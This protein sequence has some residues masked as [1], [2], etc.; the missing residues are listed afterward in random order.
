MRGPPDA[1]PTGGPAFRTLGHAA[2]LLGDEADAIRVVVDPWRGHGDGTAAHA[3]LVT[4]A[5]P[6]HCSEEDLL[7]ATL[8]G[9]PIVAPRGVA[10][11]LER[12]FPG[13][14]VSLDEGGVWT[15]AELPGLAVRA[16]PAE[17]P[18]RAA[19]FHPRGEGLVYL[20]TLGPARFLVLGDST[21]LPE[22]EKLAPDVAFLAVGDFTVMTPEEAAE[23]AARL[24]PRLAVPVHWGDTSGRF[25]A[26]R[27]F[28]ALAAARGIPSIPLRATRQLSPSDEAGRPPEAE[29]TCSS[30]RS[31]TGT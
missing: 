23:A 16:L 31:P 9:A 2:L 12:S 4:H 28:T 11:R 24:R 20:V 7:A 3:A 30:M 18:P 13:R 1:H 14:T 5:H 22:H 6:D 19:G 26:A 15:P 29:G 8:P 10:A 17:G 25:E 21:A 27:R